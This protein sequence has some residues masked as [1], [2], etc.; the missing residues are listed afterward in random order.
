MHGLSTCYLSCQLSLM[1]SLNAVQRRYAQEG[2]HLTH[3]L[4]DRLTQQE[5]TGFLLAAN[6][7]AVH[8]E[9]IE[10]LRQLIQVV[11]EPVG[12]QLIQGILQR[13]WQL[14]QVQGQR[15]LLGVVQGDG[16]GGGKRIHVLAS[17]AHDASDACMCIQKV[18]CSVALEVQHGIIT[19]L[20][21]G[22]PVIL[23]VGILHCPV[24]HCAASR[25]QLGLIHHF[26]ALCPALPDVGCAPRFGLIQQLHQP[27][28]IA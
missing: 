15:Q 3:G 26:A 17:L 21:V 27:H 19:E 4:G 20:V 14:D 12:C 5:P 16:G 24:A 23:E 9:C 10:V 1:N 28:H 25:L 11:G 13:L 7:L 8:I 6:D 22:L 2:E 18:D